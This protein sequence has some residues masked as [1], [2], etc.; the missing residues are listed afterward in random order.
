[1]PRHPGRNGATRSF[2]AALAAADGKRWLRDDSGGDFSAPLYRTQLRRL[3]F[4][5]RVVGLA[6]DL[7]VPIAQDIGRTL[8]IPGLD[9]GRARRQFAGTH[10]LVE[11]GQAIATVLDLLGVD[12]SLLGRLLAAGYLSGLW[13][14]PVLWDPARGQRVFPLSGTPRQAVGARSP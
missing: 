5:S 6:A 11:R 3:D 7:A 1:M 13:G 9:H 2:D 4:A 8:S 12:A 14:R 10:R